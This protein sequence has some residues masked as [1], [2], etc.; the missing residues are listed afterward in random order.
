MWLFLLTASIVLIFIANWYGTQLLNDM[1]IREYMKNAEDY[2]KEGRLEGAI[3]LYGKALEK[4]PGAQELLLSYADVSLK[5]NISIEEAARC[6]EKALNLNDS[7]DRYLIH[8]M[9]S[10]LY[11]RMGNLHEAE[12][13]LKSLLSTKPK[14]AETHGYLA[15][16]YERERRYDL[17]RKEYEHMASLGLSGSSDDFKSF[18]KDSGD[19]LQSIL[20]DIDSGNPPALSYY[21]LGRI[22]KQ[23]GM[24]KEAF[25]KFEEAQR[26]DPSFADSHYQLGTIYESEGNYPN[27]VEE[28]LRAIE[29][30]PNHMDALVALTGIEE[31][32]SG[33][34]QSPSN[35]ASGG[36]PQQSSWGEIEFTNGLC[37]VDFSF[38]GDKEPLKF[39]RGDR[40]TMT[41]YWKVK[42]VPPKGKD[43]LVLEFEHEN[44][45]GGWKEEKEIIYSELSPNNPL[46][47]GSVF[48][49]S[50]PSTIPQGMGSGKYL[51][52]LK[53]T[54]EGFAQESLIGHPKILLYS[55]L[56]SSSETSPGLIDLGL[57]KTFFGEKV[58]DLN[59]SATLSYGD[60]VVIDVAPTF[61]DYKGLGIIAYLTFAYWAEQGEEVASLIVT[62]SDGREKV[63]PM[64]AGIETSDAMVE[65]TNPPMRHGVAKGIAGSRKTESGQIA[66]NYFAKF[67]LSDI[68]P[69]EKIKIVYTSKKGVLNV[70]GLYFY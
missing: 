27:A 37:L 43:T 38:E 63:L 12:K 36:A 26:I 59:K 28:Y 15:T 47:P 39:A 29:L 42:R 21:H 52:S 60:T 51:V 33:S 54:G 16:V 19:K 18:V 9:L 17:A 11:L 35:E 68:A 45:K 23:K 31:K 58:M 2:E 4:H 1:S 14:S 34:E 22:Y 48:T 50:I 13:V 57:A 61:S 32:S 62:A 3:D 49:T 44:E 25:E 69:I 7:Q 41:L 46:Q 56:V 66:H 67:D 70:S 20:Q 55:F 53:I 5:A 65:G 6:L 24:W 30:L 10:R 8:I 40:V 64:R